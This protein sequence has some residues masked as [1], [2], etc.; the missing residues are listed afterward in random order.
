MGHVEPPV[1]LPP[2]INREEIEKDISRFIR[3]EAMR[4][5]CL[6]EHVVTVIKDMNL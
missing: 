4:A 3:H 2:H 6:Q 5:G 1:I